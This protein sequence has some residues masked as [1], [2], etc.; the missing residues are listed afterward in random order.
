M[1]MRKQ[2]SW[3]VLL[4]VFVVVCFY[5]VPIQ[6]HIRTNFVE[7]SYVEVSAGNS[8]L[9]SAP[10]ETSLSMSMTKILPFTFFSN[11]SV[12]GPVSQEKSYQFDGPVSNS[13][14]NGNTD[15]VLLNACLNNDNDKGKTIDDKHYD[16][17]DPD[18]SG[19]VSGTAGPND[20]TGKTANVLYNIDT[21]FSGFGLFSLVACDNKAFTAIKMAS[22]KTIKIMTNPVRYH[23]IL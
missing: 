9:M 13:A 6:A 1:R 16:D 21:Y 7:T 4:V 10:K 14:K 12:P 3:L 18:L 19:F 17:I 22:S 20:D 15:Y 2:L 5:P 11:V 23:L 8:V